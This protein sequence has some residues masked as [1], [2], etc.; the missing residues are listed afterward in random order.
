MPCT[1]H[2][3]FKNSCGVPLTPH[4]VITNSC[5]VHRTPH[6]P[7]T[8]S[9]GFIMARR[10]KAVSNEE[11]L[12][13][14][15]MYDSIEDDNLEVVDL[16]EEV[17]M[18]E[19]LEVQEGDTTDGE[20][21]QDDPSPMESRSNSP[22]PTSSNGVTPATRSQ[23]GPIDTPS[24]DPLYEIPGRCT[25]TAKD[26]TKWSKDPPSREGTRK[27]KRDSGTYQAGPTPITE[28]V[29]TLP[30]TLKLYGIKL[31]LACDSSTYYMFNANP[32]LGKGSIKKI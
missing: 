15:D 29:S 28:A 7:I 9:S 20:A 21:S 14:L 12:D 5:V 19:V 25:I 23:G 17:T 2:S 3:P 11:L 6:S 31:V 4:S 27:R 18:E 13:L 30:E 8:N 16:G 10:L 32:Y 26:G 22:T 24:F 1:P